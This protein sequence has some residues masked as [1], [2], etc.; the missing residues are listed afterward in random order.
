MIVPPPVDAGRDTRRRRDARAALAAVIWQA[1]GTRRLPRERALVDALQACDPRD[2]WWTC[3]ASSAGPVYLLPT[4]EWIAALAKVLDGLGAKKV[5]EIAAGDGFL[6]ACLQRARPRLRVV[7]TDDH[8]WTRPGARSNEQ[9]RRA[10]AGVAFAGIRAAQHVRK[11][12]AS[13][14]V[15]QE[16]P[17]V[18]LVAWAPPGTLVERAIRGPCRYVL[19]V[20]VDGDVCGAGARAWRFAKEFLEGPIEDRALCRLDARPSEQRATRVT[21]YYGARHPRHG[22]ERVLR[23]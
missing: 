16:R 1:D 9:D 5:L 7:A 20:S 21:L 22:V 19:D 17:D 2:V 4:R 3:E 11:Q 6:S 8:S 14:A 13:A 15:A 10:Y 18:V 12:R 23:G